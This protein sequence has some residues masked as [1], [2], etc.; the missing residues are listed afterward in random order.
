MTTQVAEHKSAGALQEAQLMNVLRSSL[1]PGAKDDSI[2]LVLAYC[3]QAQL[4][5]MQKPVH[6]VPMWDKS[7]KAMRDVIMPA[8]ALYR[9]QAARS[10]AY[11]GKSAPLFGPMV[12]EKL[13]GVSVAF[14]EWCEITVQRRVGD[15]IAH[16]TAREIWIENYAT[17]DRDSLAPNVMWAK[18]PSGQLAKCAEA[19]ALRMAFPELTGGM[20]TAEEMEGRHIDAEPVAEV[21]P[22]PAASRMDKFAGPGAEADSQKAK[23][24]QAKDDIVDAELAEGGDDPDL[25]LPEMP[26]TMMEAWTESGFWVAAWNWLVK[27]APELSEARLKEAGKRWKDIIEAACKSS[28]DNRAKAKQFGVS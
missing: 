27:I 16:F 7:A 19:Q 22:K 26:E 6:I 21:K 9:T 10:G 1:Y 12:L 3:G 18:R 13:G 17:K 4:D 11:V 28:A 23:T 15:T 20:A 24:V 8:I 14:P 5:V 2:R 25:A